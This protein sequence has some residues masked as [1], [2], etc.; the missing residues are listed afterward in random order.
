MFRIEGDFDFE[1]FYKKV[2]N[3]NGMQKVSVRMSGGRP[4]LHGETPGAQMVIDF[5]E[6]TFRGGQTISQNA[7]MLVSNKGIIQIFYETTEDFYNCYF[8]LTHLA[9]TILPLFV[10]GNYFDLLVSLVEM[11]QIRF[12]QSSCAM[13]LNREP[14]RGLMCLALINALRTLFQEIEKNID[15]IDSFGFFNSYEFVKSLIIPIGGSL[16]NLMLYLNED[17]EFA[18]EMLNSVF[19]WLDQLETQV[20]RLREMELEESEK[21]ATR[22]EW[23]EWMR[24]NNIW[25]ELSL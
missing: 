25:S 5:R 22:D 8:F 4:A 6:I 23:I 19:K 9:L 20:K 12:V 16:T 2:C 18:K 10:D 24:T 15:G 17:R 7:R 14:V 3:E 1:E 21:A 11:K 13:D